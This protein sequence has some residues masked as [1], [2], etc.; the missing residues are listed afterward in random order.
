MTVHDFAHGGHYIM[1]RCKNII[2]V[3]VF[4]CG[5]FYCIYSLMA[6]K[7]N[8]SDVIDIMMDSDGESDDDFDGYI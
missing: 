8:I 5:C 1:T 2:T 6:K 3:A 7:F 4:S